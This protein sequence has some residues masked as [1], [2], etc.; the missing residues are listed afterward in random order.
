MSSLGVKLGSNLL[1]Y[2]II[3]LKSKTFFECA[4]LW[5]NQFN[6]KTFLLITAGKA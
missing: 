6:Y 2:G 1:E 5:N 4:N 3:T